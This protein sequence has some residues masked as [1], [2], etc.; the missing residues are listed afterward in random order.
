MFCS[1]LANVS[2]TTSQQDQ[3]DSLPKSDFSMYDAI[4]AQWPVYKNFSPFCIQRLFTMGSS[5]NKAVA[6][7]RARHEVEVA[8]E[9]VK[10]SGSIFIITLIF[11][12][13]SR[14]NAHAICEQLERMGL[15]PLITW[16]SL[17]EK[18]RISFRTRSVY[19]RD[20]CAVEVSINRNLKFVTLIGG[21][22]R[23]ARNDYSIYFCRV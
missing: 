23:L 13:I 16:S 14:E 9:Q 4:V 19:S 18:R 3:L 17:A 10:R 21:A 6:T 7:L 15:S 5:I 11:C 12:C 22:Y 20:M 1:I 2:E 8:I